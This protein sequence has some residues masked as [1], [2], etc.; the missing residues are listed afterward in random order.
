MSW[1]AIMILVGFSSALI[2]WIHSLQESVEE[3]YKR[4]RKLEPPEDKSARDKEF[5]RKYAEDWKGKP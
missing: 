4:V 5:A 3:L 1:L 2:L